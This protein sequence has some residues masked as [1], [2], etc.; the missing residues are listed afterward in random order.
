MSQNGQEPV[1]IEQY[2][3]EPLPELPADP[4]ALEQA[5]K[6]EQDA[7]KQ[8]RDVERLA[9]RMFWLCLVCAGAAV[10]FFVLWQWR[11]VVQ[12]VPYVQV[13]QI[14]QDQQT[15]WLEPPVKL[16]DFVLPAEIL[17][18]ITRRFILS[19]SR[20]GKDEV[21]EEDRKLDWKAHDCGNVDLY[22][23][24]REPR[25]SE[26]VLV[27]VH[28]LAVIPTKSPQTLRASWEEWW[29]N[30]R[31]EVR[32]KHK[33]VADVTYGRFEPSDADTLNRNHAGVCVQELAIHEVR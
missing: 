26:I 21:D 32:S 2:L 3:A 13:L 31:M 18:D 25:P 12:E 33:Y 29:R 30:A 14:N 19:I 20:K 9:N 17:M 11:P 10:F 24:G 8:D 1:S 7:A 28:D 6:A 5:E 15:A 16:R 22:L 27:S 4:F 23:Q